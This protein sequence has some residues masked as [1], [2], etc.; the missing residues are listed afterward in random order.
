MAITTNNSMSVN[1]ALPLVRPP[2]DRYLGHLA[3]RW[4]AVVVINSLERNNAIKPLFFGG[5]RVQS[6]I[7]GGLF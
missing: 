1:A 4:A 2:A 6:K 7:A 3:G 5:N